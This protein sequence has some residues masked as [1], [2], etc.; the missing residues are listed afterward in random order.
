MSARYSHL[1]ASLR[2]RLNRNQHT[3]QANRSS[4]PSNHTE[5]TD[6]ALLHG[7]LNGRGEQPNTTKEHGS[8]DGLA[9]GIL[10]MVDRRRVL[11]GHC[12]MNFF[13]RRFDSHGEVL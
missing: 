1:H 9:D 7:V 2:P 13:D 3:E 12:E 4:C 5:R 11:G 6:V 10:G 8:L